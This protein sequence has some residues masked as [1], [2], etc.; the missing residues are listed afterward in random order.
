MAPTCPQDK[1][2]L[3]SRALRSSGLAAAS[4]AH[5]TVHAQIL[6][7]GHCQGELLLS[8]SQGPLTQAI[9]LGSPIRAVLAPD[10][11][12]FGWCVDPETQG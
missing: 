12:L 6:P 5:L 1:P 9:T 8:S 10:D 7:G 3:L 11:Q 2:E 4:S